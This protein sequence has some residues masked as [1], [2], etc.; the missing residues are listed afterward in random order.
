MDTQTE[1]VQLSTA[2]GTLPLH[3]VKPT[4]PGPFPAVVLFMD[5]FGVRPALFGMAERLVAAGYLVA[6]PDVFYRLGPSDPQHLLQMALDPAT[7]GEWMR[8]Y[9]GSAL[10]PEHVAT[11]AGAVLAHLAG[12]SDVRPGGVGTTGYCMGGHISLRTAGLFPDQVVAC[13]SFHGGG[14][15]TDAADSPHRLAPRIKASVYV[16]GAVEDPSFTDEAKQMLEEA[17]SAAGVDHQIETYAGARHG[18]A[19]P[20][21]PTYDAAASERHFVALLALLARRLG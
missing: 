13:A 14:I 20:G 19:V 4:G 18:F 2:D 8:R 3:I 1:P 17:L 10:Q 12:R 5:A 7:R 11:D 21:Q 15:A 16:A 6:L 9:I